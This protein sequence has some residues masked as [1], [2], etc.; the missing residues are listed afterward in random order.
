MVYMVCV[1]GVYMVYMV[2]IWCIYGVYGVC[3]VYI[4]CIWYK[5]PSYSELLGL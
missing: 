3:M 2:F 1:Y 5:S 4:L